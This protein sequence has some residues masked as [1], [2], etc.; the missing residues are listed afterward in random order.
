MS[1][2]LH[3]HPLASF[4]WKVLIALYENDTPFEPVIV[5]LGDE[6]SRAEFLK[7]WPYGQ[8]AGAVV[9]AAS[10]RTV[11]RIGPYRRL[12]VLPTTRRSVNS[13]SGRSGA[14][15]TGPARRPLLRFLCAR[16][17]A[18]D[19]RRHAASGRGAA[20]IPLG[21]EQARATLATVI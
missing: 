1:L 8:D 12:L 15:P 13:R 4:C 2:T 10:H 5:D 19:R 18:E 17:D 3:F 11:A 16:A 21:V 7:I 20:T 14:C 6:R 9:D